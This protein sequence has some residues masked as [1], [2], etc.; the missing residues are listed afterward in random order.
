M[1][2]ICFIIIVFGLCLTSFSQNIITG[3]ITDSETDETLIGANITLQ[4]FGGTTA[5][6]NGTFEFKN[7]P[8]VLDL[9]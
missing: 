2:K 3:I 8:I 6:Y 1:N 9:S 5:D 4:G 7:L